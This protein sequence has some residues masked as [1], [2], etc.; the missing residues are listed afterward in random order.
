MA[1]PV[2]PLPMLLRLLISWSKYL[3]VSMC[4]SI[5]SLNENSIGREGAVA[6]SE[7]LKSMTTLQELR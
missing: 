4:I 2:A 3:I 5:H 6:L 1:D 7:A